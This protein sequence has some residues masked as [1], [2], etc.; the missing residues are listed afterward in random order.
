MAPVDFA[1]TMTWSAGTKR[2][3][4]SRSTNLRMSQGHATRSTFTP[5]RVTHFMESL[6]G[7]R[8]TGTGWLP[9]SDDEGDPEPV[10]P[11]APHRLDRR[12]AHP[13]LGGEQLVEP[14]HS[15]DA[16]IGALS[17][18]HGSV[19]HDVVH[20]NQAPGSREL[21]RPREVLRNVRLV[22]V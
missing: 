21:E 19:P 8:S 18:D 7:S 4:A 11:F 22:G 15:L 3:S 5:S 2:N 12:R 13:L 20:E 6:R 10:V 17:V 14:A 16:R 9:I 1:F